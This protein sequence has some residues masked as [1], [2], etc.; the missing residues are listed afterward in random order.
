MNNLE[1]DEKTESESLEQE[2]FK[3]LDHQIR[4]DILIHIGEKKDSCSSTLSC[5]KKS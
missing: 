2:V 3:A 1:E 4:R 5:L